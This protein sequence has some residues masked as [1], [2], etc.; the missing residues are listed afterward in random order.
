M[1][2]PNV[3]FAVTPATLDYHQRRDFWKQS[4]PNSI[5][6]ESGLIT[7]LRAPLCYSHPF[8]MKYFLNLLRLNNAG[9]I[10]NS[11]TS[12]TGQSKVVIMPIF[13]IS[14]YLRPKA[15]LSSSRPTLSTVWPFGG[16]SGA[17]FVPTVGHVDNAGRGNK[18]ARSFVRW[19]HFEATVEPFSC[20]QLGTSITLD[21]ATRTLE[22]S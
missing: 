20:Q 4:M 14:L 15:P 8:V 3:C 12:S 10:C 6:F 1:F 18:N 17:L 7:M 11:G 9:C 19:G 5:C 16:Y 22:A 13:T 2:V 21:A